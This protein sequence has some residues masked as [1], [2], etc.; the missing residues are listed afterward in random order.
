MTTLL[1]WK[2][3]IHFVILEILYLPPP[4]LIQNLQT[5]RY[6]ATVPSPLHCHIASSL[7][8]H[9]H[10]TIAPLTRDSNCELR[11]SAIRIPYFSVGFSHKEG[12]HV[13]I[14]ISC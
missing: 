12:V 2:F 6:S 4:S 3:C 8:R 7:S 9:R 10:R 1:C 5:S 11:S 13:K 14:I